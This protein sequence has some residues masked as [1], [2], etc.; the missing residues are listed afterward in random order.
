MPNQPVL[1]VYCPQLNPVPVVET[2]LNLIRKIRAGRDRPQAPIVVLSGE[3]H[4]TPSHCLLPYVVCRKRELLFGTAQAALLHN[5]TF[6]AEIPHNALAIEIAETES[7]LTLS[8]IARS[9]AGANG[10]DHHTSYA[11]YF[12][13][14]AIHANALAAEQIMLS[15]LG[16][17]A[18]DAANDYSEQRR[19]WVIDVND[20]STS[21]F[22]RP[23]HTKNPRSIP[24]LVSPAGIHLRNL[25]M[26]DRLL[27][28]A[29]KAGHNA[30]LW[31]QTGGGHLLA[32]RPRTAPLLYDWHC[33][34]ARREC[35]VIVLHNLW[36]H[37][38]DAHR[39][40][41]LARPNMT[42]VLVNGL[43]E[44][45]QS[46]MNYSKS[47]PDLHGFDEEH[48]RIE[49]GQTAKIL[50]N[51]FTALGLAPAGLPQIRMRN[52]DAHKVYKKN[53]LANITRSIYLEHRRC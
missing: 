21:T 23:E 7:R 26:A 27:K 6:T 46:W 4:K 39:G 35:H 5:L 13:P 31:H 40:V 43:D 9:L 18:I 41:N 3:E 45:T 32:D 20:P 36:P 42:Q 8:Q 29:R 15:G 17:H 14:Q 48:P 53:I 16:I 49:H 22:V 33:L 24:T 2:V 47:R 19:T 10:R 50:A 1:S 30:V 44:G 25:F 28:L 51:I 37:M 52:N 11:G 12:A 34:T 38:R